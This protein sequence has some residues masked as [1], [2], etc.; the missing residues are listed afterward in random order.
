M[1]RK[2]LAAAT[3]LLM[4]ASSMSVRA[5]DSS[6]QS[7]VPQYPYKAF[8]TER[9]IPGRDTGFKQGEELQNGWADDD[10]GGIG[11]NPLPKDGDL[12]DFKHHKTYLSGYKDGLFRPNHNLTRAEAAA[13]MYGLL[14]EPITV[15]S[16]R[17]SDVTEDWYA[18]AVNA[19]ASLQIL[20]GGED[21]RYR[22]DAPM[23]RGEEND[24]IC[25]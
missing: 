4:A 14:K 6:F 23:T 8:I 11:T 19:L 10:T 9:E 22:P 3:A 16:G 2:L 5:M 12:L 25:A 13:L 18:Q 1:Q 17:F 7:V 24:Q 15:P 21:G 20:S